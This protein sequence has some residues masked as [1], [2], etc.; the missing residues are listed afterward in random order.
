MPTTLT[1]TTHSPDET[2]AIG[3]ALGEAA[4]PGDIY[5]L[6]GPLGAGKTCLVQGIAFGLGSTEYAR[7]PTFVLVNQYK[8]RLPVFHVDLFRIEDALEAGDMGL[9]EYFERGVCAVEWPERAR[10]VFP[11]DYMWVDIAYGRMESDRVLRFRPHGARYRALVL[12]LREQ[13]GRKARP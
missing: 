4:K 5:L 13:A 3:R 8:G 11:R 12:R 9:E 7:S 2:R 1:L 6:S 10:Q